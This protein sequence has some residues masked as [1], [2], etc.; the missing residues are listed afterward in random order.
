MVRWDSR[1]PGASGRAPGLWVAV[2][3]LLAAT[4]SL[5]QAQEDP[6][7]SSMRQRHRHGGVR[8]TA[9]GEGADRFYL[10]EPADPVP[11]RAPVV[12]FHH[13]WRGINP[14][15]F[16]SWIDHLVRRG[17]VV[18]FPV[19]QDPDRTSPREALRRALQADRA[20]FRLLSGKGHVRPDDQRVLSFGFSMGASISVGLAAGAARLGL[21]AIR[22][23]LLLHPGDA[24]HVASGTE[25]RSILRDIGKVPRETRVVVL[26][27]DEDRLV[28]DQT[29]KDILERLCHLPPDR[30]TWWRLRSGRQGDLHA[31]AGHGAPG[32][33]DPRYDFG[34]DGSAWPRRIPEGEW[35]SPSK[36]LNLLDLYGYWR[37]GDALVDEV[38][39]G[40]PGAPALGPPPDPASMGRWPDG[41]PFPAAEAPP[42]VCRNTAGK[43]RQGRRLEPPDR[44]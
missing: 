15:N 12:F 9:A 41:T 22:G 11:E 31:V 38:M 25:A 18:V 24:R 3:C 1:G 27:G 34:A 4:P 10:F 29:A 16:G 43:G 40:L 2:A 30:R 37:W 35:P 33:P 39:A 20:A 5:G 8:V 14:L 44:R 28:G 23:L 42:D 13:G 21:P 19:Y 7:V 6:A 36:S 26:T 32:A 17:V